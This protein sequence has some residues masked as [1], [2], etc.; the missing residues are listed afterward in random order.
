[1]QSLTLCLFSADAIRSFIRSDILEG[2]LDVAP[3]TLRDRRD[4]IQGSSQMDK[5]DDGISTY[6]RILLMTAIIL[7]VPPAGSE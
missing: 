3:S 5:P 4:R 6:C 1:M 2:F 7:V